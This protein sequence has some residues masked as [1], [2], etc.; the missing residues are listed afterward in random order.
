VQE[1]GFE[2]SLCAAL[3]S[4]GDG[5]V[6]RQLGGGVHDPGGRV[7]DTVRVVP[8]PEFD[9]RVAL[10]ADAIPRLAID[11]EVGPGRFRFWRDAFP[12]VGD[13]TARRVTDAA[14]EAGFFEAERR[15]GRR[16]VRQ[17]ARYPDWVDGLVGIENKPDLDRPGALETQLRTD[18]SLGLLDRVV[19][20]TESYVTGAHLNRIPDPVG[21]WRFDP[22]TGE[23]AVVRAATP[24]A[25]DEAGVELLGREP[26]RAEV[27]IVGAAA[28][29]AAR[30]RIAERAYGKGWRTYE[31]PGCGAFAATERHGAG[32]VPYCR[33]FDR[34]VD[35]ATDCGPECPGYEPA[36][37]ADVDRDGARADNAAWDPDPPGRVRRQS[38]LSRYRGED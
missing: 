34:V 27:R 17:V 8:G 31:P 19:L 7:L 33:H 36:E 26:T 24:L 28:K 12:D 14:V 16:Y 35:P 21:V 38:S 1:F 6:A 9:E 32:A 4:A 29:A 10:S 5:V 23:R 11:S 2:L 37:P 3:E 15:G 30:R 13:E 25:T 20:A 18:V 22:E